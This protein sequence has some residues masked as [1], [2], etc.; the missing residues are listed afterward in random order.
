M[1]IQKWRSKNPRELSV[2]TKVID[3]LYE[4]EFEQFENIRQDIF[5]LITGHDL[6]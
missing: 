3:Q 1:S 4:E 6:E 2:P 5:K